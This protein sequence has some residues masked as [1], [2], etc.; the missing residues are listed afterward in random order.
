MAVTAGK[1]AL[2]DSRPLASGWL[3]MAAGGGA[4]TT[5]ILLDRSASTEQQ[6]LQTARSKRSV[7]VEKLS[8]FFQTLGGAGQLVLIENTENVAMVI[9]E[10][11]PNW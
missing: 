8:D 7:A 9:D 4:D 10:L 5:I 3:G 11:P 6:E 1:G 2:G